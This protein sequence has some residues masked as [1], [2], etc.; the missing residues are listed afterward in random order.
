MRQT[1]ATNENVIA[2][3]SRFSTAQAAVGST[4]AS[5]LTAPSMTAMGASTWSLRPT[6]PTSATSA[7]YFVPSA[8][9]THAATLPTVVP[10]G[11][12]TPASPPSAST[13]QAAT[14]PASA[15]AAAF[16]AQRLSLSGSP[17]ASSPKVEGASQ[18]A[19]AT[20]GSVATPSMIPRPAAKTPSPGQVAEESS[21]AFLDAFART[22]NFER[23]APTGDSLYV[24]VAHTVSSLSLSLPVSVSFD[25]SRLCLFRSPPV[26]VSF[27]LPR[28]L[29]PLISLVFSFA[30]VCRRFSSPKC[31][32]QP[33]GPIHC[34]QINGCE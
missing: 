2:Y 9:T 32:V 14:G 17:A 20:E 16:A 33:Q 19:M 18:P 22:G 26:S 12:A 4:T 1:I 11:P 13:K 24:S 3:L 25:L 27:D 21:A 23:K 8:V 7:S 34:H 31:A 15:V 28:S 5:A 6:F 29:F 10:A 30:S